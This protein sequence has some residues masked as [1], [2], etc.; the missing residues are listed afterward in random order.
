MHDVIFMLEGYLGEYLSVYK[1]LGHW[2]HYHVTMI[3]FWHLTLFFLTCSMKSHDVFLIHD[4]DLVNTYL[5]AR[6]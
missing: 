2:D 6:K 4:Y 5:Q 1:K 3:Y